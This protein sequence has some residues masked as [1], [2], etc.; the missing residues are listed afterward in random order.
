MRHI[1]CFLILLTTLPL[2]EVFGKDEYKYTPLLAGNKQWN[3][4][5]ERSEEGRWTYIYKLDGDTIINGRK[6]WILYHTVD[7]QAKKNGANKAI[8]MKILP[9]KKYGFTPCK[10][11]TTD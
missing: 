2:G 6:Y 3:V 1:V 8:Y 11:I 4:L 7:K 9:K 5:E 10:I